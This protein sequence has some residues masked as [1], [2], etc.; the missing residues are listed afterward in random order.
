M[1]AIDPSLP[2][3]GYSYGPESYDAVNLIALAAAQAKSDTG[4]E[5]AAEMQDVSEGGKTC[6]SFKDCN[7][8]IKQGEDIDYNG[9][10]GPVEFDPFGDPTV[11]LDR[12]LHVRRQEPGPWPER[13]MAR[14]SRSVRRHDGTEHGT[15]RS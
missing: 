8:L 3:V 1:N 14:H 2:D 10:S 7:D 9:L 13:L 11:S 5:M 15:R 4:L 6:T 12:D